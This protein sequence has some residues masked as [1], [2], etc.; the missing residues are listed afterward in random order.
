MDDFPKNWP[1]PERPGVP[2]FPNITARHVLENKRRRAL[3]LVLWDHDQDH[4]CTEIG[5]VTPHQMIGV[6]WEYYAPVL[7]PAQIAEMLAG[8]RERC[9]KE[10][11]EK[12]VFANNEAEE[13]GSHEA[14][15]YWRGEHCAATFCADV[16][17]S[18][19]DAA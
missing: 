8:E 17:R 13:A 10:C 11:D 6:D 7:T 18:M 1:N 15:R 9:A 3:K 19:G 16:I 4:Y 5:Y 14:E 2:M 12:A